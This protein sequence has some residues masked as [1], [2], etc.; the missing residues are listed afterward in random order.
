MIAKNEDTPETD[1]PTAEDMA[2]ALRDLDPIKC[3]WLLINTVSEAGSISISQAHL[4][5]LPD[6]PP[7]EIRYDDE[8]GM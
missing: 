5:A 3:L 7:L 4:D 6:P 2:E 1:E 8:A